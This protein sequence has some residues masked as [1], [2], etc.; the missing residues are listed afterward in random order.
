MKDH[1]YVG[2]KVRPGF[3][4]IA[5]ARC[6]TATCEVCNT[7]TVISDEM[8]EQMKKKPGKIVCQFC[9][10]PQMF[11]EEDQKMIA[12]MRGEEEAPSGRPA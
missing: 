8:V 4:V 11:G 12:E 2:L 5:T 7:P 10:D 3:A 1:Y 9:V 6:K